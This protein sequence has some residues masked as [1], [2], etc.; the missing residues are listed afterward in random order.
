MNVS[1]YRSEKTKVLKS[2]IHGKGLFA[3]KNIKKD[4]IVAIKGGHII[5]KKTLKAKKNIIGDSSCQIS[6]NFFLAPLTKKEYDKVMLFFNHSC[7]PNTGIMG[8]I[9]FVALKDIPKNTELTLDYAFYK[10]ESDYGFTCNC[11][12]T[13]CRKKVT[14]KDWKKKEVQKKYRA[15]FSSFLQRKKA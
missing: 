6:E 14:G 7:E 1:S 2:H 4:E 15:Y 12:S 8:N 5:D 13:F 3:V 9:V 11:S 10:D